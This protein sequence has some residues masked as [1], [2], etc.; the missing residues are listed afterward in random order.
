MYRLNHHTHHPWIF[1]ASSKVPIL[2]MIMQYYEVSNHWVLTN[3]TPLKKGFRSRE[4][5]ACH[6]IYLA[7]EPK[8]RL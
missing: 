2:V 4:H 1:L 5:L 3:Q 8:T 6:S 7:F